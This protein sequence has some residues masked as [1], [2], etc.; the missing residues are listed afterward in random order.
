MLVC[1]LGRAV[2]LVVAAIALCYVTH[3]GCCTLETLCIGPSCNCPGL[4]CKLCCRVRQPWPTPQWQPL[5]LNAVLSRWPP[6]GMQGFWVSLMAQS[7]CLTY[8]DMATYDDQCAGLLLLGFQVGRQAE[9]PCCWHFP[10]LQ[11]YSSS[12]WSSCP[13][14]AHP[15]P[16]LFSSFSNLQF[17]SCQERGS[18]PFSWWG[19]VSFI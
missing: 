11:T 7:S 19:R 12:C 14:V 8:K 2:F 4:L 3:P 6:Q 17:S 13:S 9:A 15:F 1:F 16:L 5:A 10:Q 18:S